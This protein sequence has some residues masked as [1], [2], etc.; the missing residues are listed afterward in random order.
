MKPSRFT[1]LAPMLALVGIV[2]VSCGDSPTEP[3][4]GPLEL[5]LRV[6][7]FQSDDVPALDVTL[8]DAEVESLVAAVN[9]VWGQAEVRFEMVGLGREP[10]VAEESYAAVIRGE[11][12]LTPSVLLSQISV[13]N[14]DQGSWNVYMVNDFGGAI[15]GVYIDLGPVVFSAELDPAGA[16]EPTGSMARILAHELGHALGLPH[17]PCMAEGNLM[18]AGCSSGNRTRLDLEQVAIARS[19]AASGRPAD[20]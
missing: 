2:S 20:F 19:Q 10:A 1:V 17:V 11:I 15:G 9:A 12:P 5:P 7:L 14:F 4:A 18:A 3:A 8:S 16:R 13:A 6:H